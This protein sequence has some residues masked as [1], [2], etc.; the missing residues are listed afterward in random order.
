[1]DTI[2]IQLFSTSIFTTSYAVI[3][4]NVILKLPSVLFK[5]FAQQISAIVLSYGMRSSSW[6]ENCRIVGEGR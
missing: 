6:K 1:M 4:T 2:S 3:H 5:A